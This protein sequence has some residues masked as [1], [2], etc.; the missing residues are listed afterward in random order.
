M[1]KTKRRNKKLTLRES[2]LMER[3]RGRITFGQAAQRVIR[4]NGPD[5][6]A[7]NR[8]ET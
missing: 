3:I 6:Q 5:R 7:I 8:S 1:K 2:A 4:E